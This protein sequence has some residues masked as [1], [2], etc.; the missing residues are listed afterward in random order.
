ELLELSPRALV[1]RFA[2]LVFLFFWLWSGA[3][4]VLHYARMLRLTRDLSSA[5]ALQG[6][7]QLFL[8]DRRSFAAT[9]SLGL[10]SLVG[11]G[12]LIPLGHLAAAPL[13]HAL[14]VGSA[15][16]VR[17]VSA[18]LRTV[19]ALSVIAGATEVW[20]DFAGQLP[21]RTPSSGL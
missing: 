18:L 15:F 2:P 12:L 7:L 6:A 13:D 19:L 20:H 1:L 9:L 5:A 10:V 3:S 17:Q 21:S 8:R 4:V 16:V 14:F 11:Y